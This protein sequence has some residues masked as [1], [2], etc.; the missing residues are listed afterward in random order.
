VCRALKNLKSALKGFKK[1]MQMPKP[2]R[3]FSIVVVK[4]VVKVAVVVSSLETGSWTGSESWAQ[5]HV[6]SCSKFE[7][8]ALSELVTFGF[9]VVVEVVEVVDVTTVSIKQG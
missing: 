9:A 3:T 8:P 4:V 1:D 7:F 2:G 5:S 6:H